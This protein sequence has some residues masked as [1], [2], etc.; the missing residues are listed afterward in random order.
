M[1]TMLMVL[2]ASISILLILCVLLQ[3][4]KGAE[5]G[6]MGGGASDAVLSGSQRGN[7]LGK[8]TAVLATLFLINSL[9][10][11]RLQS[12]YTSKSIL[13]TEAPVT[14]PLSSDAKKA[15]APAAAKDAKATESTAPAA[16]ATDTKTDKK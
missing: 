5:V 11:A 8:I 10:L 1:I 7:I 3:F 12:N 13:D 2:Q 16:K 15:D 9:F 14:R 6:L 4:G